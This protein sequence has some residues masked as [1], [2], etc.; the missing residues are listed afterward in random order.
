MNL[1]WRKDARGEAERQVKLWLDEVLV[2]LDEA[3]RC[4]AVP[5]LQ[6]T[7]KALKRAQSELDT[8]MQ[9]ERELMAEQRSLDP[10]ANRTR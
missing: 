1:D 2:E 3:A 4:L 5:Y 8:A 6:G 7:F 9:L 10:L